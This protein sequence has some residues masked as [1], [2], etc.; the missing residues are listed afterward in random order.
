MRP[1]I[2]QQ[3][4]VITHEAVNFSAGARIRRAYHVQNI[5]TYY[6]HL[7]NW[8]DHFHG[9]ATKYLPNRLGWRRAIDTR[10]LNTP[11]LFLH[12]AIG[13]LPHSSMT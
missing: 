12:T 8:L 11:E 7:K 5:N 13:L 4:I 2:W 9:A 1:L 6:G 10:H 3:E